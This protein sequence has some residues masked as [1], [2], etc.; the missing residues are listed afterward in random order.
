MHE[1][2][3]FISK[4]VSVPSGRG[5]EVEGMVECVLVGGGH[6]CVLLL[7]ACRGLPSVAGKRRKTSRPPRGRQLQGGAGYGL[8]ILA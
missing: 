7:L 3:P 1:S 5:L 8:W 6:E 2:S 4:P